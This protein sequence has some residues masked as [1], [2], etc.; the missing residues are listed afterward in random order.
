M[1]M[2]TR[3]K[4]EP[5]RQYHRQYHALGR[6]KYV[7]A[8]IVCQSKPYGMLKSIEFNGAQTNE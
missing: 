3:D 7:N 6:H 4:A 1:S 8:V 2:Y 5:V